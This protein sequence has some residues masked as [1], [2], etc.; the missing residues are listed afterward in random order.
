MCGIVGFSGA[1]DSD[2]LKKMSDSIFHRGP[3]D[4]G[5]IVNSAFSVGFRRLAI[6]DLTSSIYPLTNEE[7]TIKVVLNGEIYNYEKLRQ[8]LI[9]LGHKFKT[10]SD[11]EVIAHGYEEWGKGVV[12][13]L[14]GMFVFVI[15]DEIN[16]ELF[17]ARD[18]VGIK[19]FYYTEVEDRIV[20]S[21]EIKGILSGFDINREPNDANVMKFL[22]YRVH[23]IDETTFFKNIKRLL[24]GHT[25]TIRADGSFVIEKYWNPTYN[26]NF[27]STKSDEEYAAEFREKFLETIKLHLIADVPVGTTLSGG[28]DSSGVTS[29]AAKFY[30]E[31]HSDQKL[32]SFSAIHPGE[33]INEEGFIDS[34]VEYTGVES[35]KVTPNVDEF[36]SELDLW[37]YFQEEP[38]ISGAPYA[39]YVVMREARKYV[40]VI[41]SG[42]GGDEL[43][44]G[45]IPYFMSYWHSAW[46]QKK[47]L[48]A[49]SELFSGRDLYMKFILMKL[50]SYF[51]K[52][53]QIRPVEFLTKDILSKLEIPRFVHKRNLNERLF[54]DVTSSTTQCLLRY[55]DKNSMA[56]S[57]ESRVPF[58]DHEMVEYIFNLPMDQKIKHGW[59]RYVYRNAMKGLMPDRN[60]LRRSKIGFTNPEW[61]WIERKKDRFMS[62]FD[63]EKFRSRKYWDADKVVQGFNKA[64]KNEL[65][66]DILFFWRLFSVEM[67]LR[68][69]VDDFQTRKTKEYV[70][71]R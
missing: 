63:S 58:Y 56:N 37:T 36:W 16:Q 25:M 32:Y 41:L 30:K 3:D 65:R 33:T 49:L 28:L 68:I 1:P 55:E 39:Y 31:E 50:D 29:L 47:P 45:Y 48:K 2:T 59:N 64:L 46:D 60:R 38:V 17:I 51:Q 53:N 27:A 40:T 54:E 34:V 14:R 42:Q 20:F 19:P 10:H 62:I 12:K 18:R 8:E 67:W 71:F 5:F 6:V 15:Y 61:E 24:S 44:A 7:G 22:A 52:S 21:S 35:I 4:E 70:H 69:F 11:T 43:L 9:N 13:R 23:D 66:G 26:S 57:L